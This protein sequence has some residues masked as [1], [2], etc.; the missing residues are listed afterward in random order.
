MMFTIPACVA[1]DSPAPT[2]SCWGDHARGLQLARRAVGLAALAVA[3]L[4]PFELLVSGDP[5][6]AALE[7]VVLV[8]L[9]LVF[10]LLRPAAG[11]RLELTK[12][13]GT[14]SVG[15]VIL[16][17]AIDGPAADG[18]LVWLALFPPVP[19]F[20]FGSRR[21]LTVAAVFTLVV[22]G[23]LA[24]PILAGAA[25]GHSW[26]AVVN[27]G[28]VLT[29]STALAHL[30]ERARA[31]STGRL[32]VAANTDLLTGAPNRRGFLAGFNCLRP[33]LE[34]RGQPMSLLVFDVDRLKHINDRYGHAAGDAALRHVARVVQ[35][36][37]REQDLLGRL[38]GDEFAL[39]LPDTHLDG[40]LDVAAKLQ[41]AL[42]AR[43]LYFN[44]SC[45]HVTLSI[46][47]AESPPG[48]IDF[49]A[50]F[51]AAD[52]RLYRAKEHGRDSAVCVRVA[53]PMEPRA[54]LVLDEDDKQDA[55]DGD[56][57][58]TDQNRQVVEHETIGN[59]AGNQKDAEDGHV[60]IQVDA[61]KDRCEAEQI[62]QDEGIALDVEEMAHRPQEQQ[63]DHNGQ[64]APMRDL[65]SKIHG[66]ASGAGAGAVPA[67]EGRHQAHD[68]NEELPSSRGAGR[69]A[70]GGRDEPDGDDEEDCIGKDI[71]QQ[72]VQPSG[73]QGFGPAA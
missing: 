19:F 54:D 14:L 35:A 23:L 22:V 13:I 6:H 70:G 55:C 20:V 29:L 46:G 40:A 56:A 42:R 18:V 63:L 67:A 12:W 51:A 64:G 2:H 21:G 26:L 1:I 41:A 4:I 61:G 10:S 25:S 45:L 38:G 53:A 37:V 73:Q 7:A 50:L 44:G 66:F 59:R 8:T 72:E 39:M 57:A 52:R 24:A 5:M 17:M 58:D 69:L 11:S 28:A 36:R 43:P 65:L 71:H 30:F 27:A 48:S 34:R 32:Y 33:L 49:D 60:P 47:A 62:D 9:L 31:D 68:R 15:G 3:Q 16:V